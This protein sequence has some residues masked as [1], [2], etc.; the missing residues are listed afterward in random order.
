M[1]TDNIQREKQPE[2]FSELSNIDFKIRDKIKSLPSHTNIET[3]EIPTSK[4]D[5][6]SFILF[7]RHK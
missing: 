5:L 7:Q 1:Q 4:K 2:K 6:K 3:A